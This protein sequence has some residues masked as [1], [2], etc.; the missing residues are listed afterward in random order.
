LRGCCSTRCA[1][2][3]LSAAIEAKLQVDTVSHAPDTMHKPSTFAL[4]NATVAD[5]PALERLIDESVRGLSRQD[6]SDAQIEAALGSAFGLDQELIRDGTYFVAEAGGEIVGCGG[7][8]RRKTL[9]G[10]DRQPGRRSEL[11][12]PVRDSARVRAFFVKPSWSRRGI[13][14]A[15]IERSE[16]EALASGFRSTELVATLAGHRLYEAFGYVGD[17]RS[18]YQLPGGVAI[19]FI[20]MRKNLL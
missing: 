10:G 14:R 16:K 20:P 9:F 1:G 17:E 13:G 7:W 15:L 18:I 5:A 4:R 3:R 11:L 2:E 6:Y 19:E 8:S 12:D